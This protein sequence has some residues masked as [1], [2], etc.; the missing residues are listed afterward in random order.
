MSGARSTG[1]LLIAVIGACS[2]NHHTSLPATGTTKLSGGPLCS[3]ASPAA[4]EHVADQV[5]EALPKGEANT[6]ITTLEDRLA[7]SGG[8]CGAVTLSPASTVPGGLPAPPRTERLR[9]QWAGTPGEDYLAAQNLAAFLLRP[10]H[11]AI[12]PILMTARACQLPGDLSGSAAADLT[13]PGGCLHL[14]APLLLAPKVE[15]ASVSPTDDARTWTLHI[16][17]DPTSL[18]P[19]S[20]EA[21]RAVF[22]SVDGFGIG[23]TRVPEQGATFDVMSRFD[24]GAT[25]A[26]AVTA[27]LRHPIPFDI[28]GVS[29]SE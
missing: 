7:A 16:L 28:M 21:G 3:T 12:R 11:L 24:G 29:V 23:E 17:L 19:W 13:T 2:G 26:M 25:E 5:I 4:R 27:N 9:M 20:A 8:H 18:G 6:L 10:G 14:G 22:V 15:T 1:L